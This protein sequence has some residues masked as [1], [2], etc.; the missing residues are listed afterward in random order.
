M[1]IAS[2]CSAAAFGAESASVLSAP[3]T[4]IL[5][6]VDVTAKNTRWGKANNRIISEMTFPGI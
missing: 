3:T 6:I 4:R 1:H 5:V 2:Y